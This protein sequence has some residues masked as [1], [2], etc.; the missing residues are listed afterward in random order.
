MGTMT[1]H[2]GRLHPVAP[3]AVHVW[4]GFR[5][6]EKSYD[7]F[8]QFLGSVFVPACAL[9]QP[10]AGLRAYLPAMPSQKDKP[11]SV[12][13]QTALMFWKDAQ[14]HDQAFKTVAVRAYTNLHGNV[15]QP[16]TTVQVPLV[17]DSSPLVI[18]QPYYL[19]DAPADWM[20]GS[21]RHFVGARPNTQSVTQFLAAVREWAVA[22]QKARP[23]SVDGALICAGNDYV[24]FWQH[25]PEPEKDGSASTP[26]DDLPRLATSFLCKRAEPFRPPAGLWDAWSGIDLT[27]Y[28]CINIQLERPA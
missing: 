28:D 3:N 13:D 11:P 1:M 24:A 25:S 12:P 10:R 18:E 4:R 19:F 22:F 14:A 20:L 16:G 21:V 2:S 6:T 17:L 26:F 8:A 7:D 9:L 5:S 15:Y 27:Q 23:A